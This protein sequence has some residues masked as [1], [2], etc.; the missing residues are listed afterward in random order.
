MPAPPASLAPEVE[1]GAEQRTEHSMMTLS[2]LM[3]PRAAASFASAALSQGVPAGCGGANTSTT[4]SAGSRGG[5][6]RQAAR[7]A[8][9]SDSLDSLAPQ[10]S[11]PAHQTESAEA[12]LQGVEGPV[13]TPAPPALLAPEVE[14]GARQRAEHVG[15]TLQLR[16][17]VRM[18]AFVQVLS[19]PGSMRVYVCVALDSDTVH[20]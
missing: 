6:G 14:L 2:A 4:K 8:W 7:Q 3:N 16:G 1:L 18:D 12:C 5:G 10:S 20:L 9:Q 11:G 15:R 13:L 19:L 17:L